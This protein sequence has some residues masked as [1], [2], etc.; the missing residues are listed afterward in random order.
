MSF[1]RP[2]LPE[3]IDRAEAEIASRLGTGPL[4]PRSVLGVLAR[5][6]AGQSHMQHGHLDWIAEQILPDTADAEHLD[7]H[8]SIWAVLRKAATYAR[9]TVQFT[10]SDGSVIPAG[11]E[12]QSAGALKFTTDAEGT[13]AGGTADVAVTAVEAGAGGNLPASTPLTLVSPIAGVDSALA[14]DASGL[15]GGA[16]TEDDE[17]LRTRLLARIQDPPHGG[18]DADYRLWALEVTEVTRAWVFPLELGLGTVTVRFVVDDHAT[19][20]IPDAAKVAAVQ[21]YLDERRPVT[22]AVTA[23]APVELQL[24]PEIQLTPA[25]STVKAAVQASLEDLLQREAEPGGTLLLSHIREAISV[26]AGET[27]HVLVSPTANV[28]ATDSQILT[29]G[30]ITWS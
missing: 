1:Q 30:T 23:V 27:D 9:G 6:L 5:V 20:I 24:D 2:S 26:A 19:S 7:R 4:L 17:D 10:G 12:V 13:I 11:T 28:V 18:S 8:A 3:L 25:T 14:V 15:A 16:D 22:A 29:L 21:A